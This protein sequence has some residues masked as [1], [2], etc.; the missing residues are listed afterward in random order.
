MKSLEFF[1]RCLNKIAFLYL[2]QKSRRQLL[3]MESHTLRDIG[4]SYED[5]MHEGSLPFWKAGIHD[6]QPCSNESAKPEQRESEPGSRSSIAV[7]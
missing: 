1:N 3:S 6:P 4:V 7:S 5:A 2:R